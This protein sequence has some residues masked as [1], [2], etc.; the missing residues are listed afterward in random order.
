MIARYHL[1]ITVDVDLLYEEVE[2][3]DI[4]NDYYISSEAKRDIEKR[5]INHLRKFLYDCDVELMTAELVDE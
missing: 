1:N 5:M 2:D 4:P 3:P